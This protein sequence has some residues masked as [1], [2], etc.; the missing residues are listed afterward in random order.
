MNTIIAEEYP[1]LCYK[2]WVLKVFEKKS[3]LFSF[4]IYIIKRGKKHHSANGKAFRK[5]FDGLVRNVQHLMLMNNRQK[6]VLTAY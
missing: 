6:K 4:H 3:F 2:S 5:S 1:P